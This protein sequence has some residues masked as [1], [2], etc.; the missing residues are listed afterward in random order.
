MASQSQRKILEEN[1]GRSEAEAVEAVRKLYEGLELPKVYAMYKK[2][3]Y[4]S[5]N[6]FIQR[7]AK[8]LPT[9]MFLIFLDRLH[10]EKV[11]W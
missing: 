11:T 2:D 10:E 7:S 6:S 5:I 8:S 1:Y 4:K 3:C 9:D